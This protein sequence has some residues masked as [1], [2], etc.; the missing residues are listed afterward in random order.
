[1]KNIKF[2]EEM[3]DLRDPVMGETVDS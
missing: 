2:V 3:K 1:M